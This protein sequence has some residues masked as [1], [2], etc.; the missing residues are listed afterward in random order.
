MAALPC[1]NPNNREG[2]DE[3]LAAFDAEEQAFTVNESICP[4]T[5]KL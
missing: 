3:A 2:F 5:I 1:F 4:R